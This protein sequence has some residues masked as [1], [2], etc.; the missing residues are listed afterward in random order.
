M[1]YLQR[2]GQPPKLGREEQALFV[3]ATLEQ[4]PTAYFTADSL[5]EDMVRSCSL[6][7]GSVEC[8]LKALDM[9]GIPEIQPDYYPDCLQSFLGR[10]VWE[11][12]V[13]DVKQ[14]VARGE[15]L[16]T[17]PRIHWKSFDGQIVKPGM[18]DNPLRDF[19]DDYP[20]WLSETVEFV[21][22]FRCYVTNSKLIACCQYSGE[23]DAQPALNCIERAIRTLE[24]QSVNLPASYSIDF[25]LTAGGETLLVEL[26][27]GF[28]VG[29][30]RGL[31]KEEYFRFLKARWDQLTK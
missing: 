12:T 15:T 22:E 21:S 2:Y 3:H 18:E 23:E 4:M 7:V 25:G 9:L 27:D 13:L 5:N 28:S 29:L 17:K 1:L 20:V 31:P 8:Y 30:Y 11:G 6:L 26:G 19:S 16:F 10:N 14:A 24:L